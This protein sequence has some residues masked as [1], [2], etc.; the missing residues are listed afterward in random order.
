MR[1]LARFLG[2][3]FRL[4]RKKFDRKSFLN[5]LL[6]AIG[7]IGL[8]AANADASEP[9]TAIEWLNDP[10]PV[11]VA[12]PLVSPL[13]QTDGEQGVLTPGVEVSTIN[14]S[15]PGAAGLL[16]AASTG[17]PTSIWLASTA[18]TLIAQF[19][20]L[21][22]DPLPAIQSLYY[23]L[24]LAEAEPPNDQTGSAR[25]L[26]AR[27]AALR[28]Y[29]AVEPALA[30]IEQAGPSQ[31]L[32]FQQWM[33]LSLLSGEEAGPCAAL[34]NAPS[35]TDRYDLRIYCAA[36]NG[37][38]ATA[39]LTYDS[40][41]A[42]GL[43]DDV[44]DALL[45]QYL[46]PELADATRKPKKGAPVTPLLFRLYETAGTPLPTGTL[47]RDYAV[48]DLRG[49]SGWKAE[50]E[51]AERLTRAGA[52][53]ANRLLGLYTQ[54]RAS[55]S[56]GVW[57]R[58]REVQNLD[59]ALSQ[60]DRATIS[61]ILPG[62]WRAMRQERLAVAFSALFAE[63]LSRHELTGQARQTAFKMA[64]LAPDYERLA[65]QYDPQT[66]EQSFLLS[67]VDSAPDETLAANPAAR[68]VAQAFNAQ[69]AASGH[70]GMLSEG[71]LG[72]AILSAALQLDLAGPNQSSDIFSGLST[73]R[74][75]GLEDTARRAALQILLLRVDA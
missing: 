5:R 50:I 30:L 74:N 11:S 1:I 33:E 55:A 27:L 72:Q 8:L 47:P 73:L 37:D 40:A 23:T 48:A 14:T 52:V 62:L 24:L 66:R 46:D 61:E 3:I 68:A 25:F 70:E 67:L 22:S 21:P 34:G 49:L 20:R 16:S 39:A 41:S 45:A 58:V 4:L 69:S 6:S 75:V 38:W 63:R 12:Q 9:L 2:S 65:R 54:Q 19:A 32:L 57:D 31:A 29:G 35:L 28:K 43:L 36:Q 17:L 56:G 53:P 44:T 13:L 51:A 64:L 10:A 71:R 60:N 15:Q 59:Q 42:L 18:D 7:V 26:N